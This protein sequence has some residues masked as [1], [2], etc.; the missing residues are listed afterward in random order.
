MRSAG[1]C[2]RNGRS[3]ARTD[4]FHRFMELVFARSRC[5]PIGT[6]GFVSE[7][8]FALDNI[9]CVIFR[10]RD[11]FR[12]QGKVSGP[13]LVT[14]AGKRERGLFVKLQPDDPLEVSQVPTV[15]PCRSAPYCRHRRPETQYKSP[16][17]AQ[18]SDID[19]EQV[20]VS[21]V[22]S[23]RNQMRHQARGRYGPRMASPEQGRSDTPE[24]FRD[25]AQLSSHQN[26]PSIWPE[27]SRPIA[28]AAG[29][30]GK[31]G[32]V[33]MSPQMATT[34]SAPADKRTSRT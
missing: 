1:D 10:P 26:S 31:P 13:V 34:N 22:S 23:S 2:R 33:M 3:G 8:Q 27:S 9:A 14:R 16:L 30:L 20:S 15:L 24:Q 4:F 12:V 6:P 29:T 17:R 7:K 21:T 28:L 32:M 25:A 11:I 19:D 5:S 18:S